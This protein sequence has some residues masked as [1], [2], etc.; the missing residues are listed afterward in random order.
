[1]KIADN[2]MQIHYNPEELD[3]LGS[4]LDIALI[5]LEEKKKYFDYIAVDLDRDISRAY[6]LRHRLK[7]LGNLE[8]GN[9]VVFT[10]YEIFLLIEIICDVLNY[11]K[12]EEYPLD[13]ITR[14]YL[15]KKPLSD[16]IL[17]KQSPSLFLTKKAS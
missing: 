11:Y 1:M 17:S 9:F 16:S 3:I 6:E 8:E 7:T 4:C 14:I 12:E 5:Q 10:R 13:T 15:A 2:S